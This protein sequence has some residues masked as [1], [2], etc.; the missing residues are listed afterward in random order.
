MEEKKREGEEQGE[1]A[2]VVATYA[3]KDKRQAKAKLDTMLATIQGKLKTQ[4]KA[5]SNHSRIAFGTHVHT[6][7]ALKTRRH[8]HTYT[9]TTRDTTVHSPKQRSKHKHGSRHKYKHQL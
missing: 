2:D 3:N 7:L 8:T 4:L 5:L 6:V 9:H 1:I